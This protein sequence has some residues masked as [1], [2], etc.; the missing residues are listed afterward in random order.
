MISQMNR[1]SILNSIIILLINI[2]LVSIGNSQLKIGD[3]APAIVLKGIN[4][5]NIELSDFKGKVVLIDFW[6]SWCAPCRKANPKLET[7]YQKHKS[8]DF[9]VLGVSLDSKEASWINAIKKDRMTYPHVIDTENWNSQIVEAYGVE[10]LPASFLI[11]KN[12][13]IVALNPT[14]EQIEQE[15]MQ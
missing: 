5:S 1:T 13:E 8:N 3:L 6:A 15:M 11:N 14:F 2:C 10:N 7:L 12:G 9:L 4:G